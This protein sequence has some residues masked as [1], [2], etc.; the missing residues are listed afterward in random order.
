MVGHGATGPPAPKAPED[1]AAARDGPE[2][3][4]RLTAATAAVLLVLLAAEGVTV[5]RIHRLLAAHVF[6]GMLLIPPVVLKLGSTLYRFGRYSRG[7]VPT[8]A[9]ARPLSSCGCSG[10]SS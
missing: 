5:L 10:P 9:R 4:A 6:I 1:R 7:R 2:A 8:G 3:N